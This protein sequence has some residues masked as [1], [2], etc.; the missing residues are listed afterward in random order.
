[1]V[2]FKFNTKA[3]LNKWVMQCRFRCILVNVI[4]DH[5]AEIAFF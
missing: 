2:T 4:D 5:T 3:K 1:M